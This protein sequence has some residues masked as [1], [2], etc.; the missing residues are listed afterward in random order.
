MYPEERKIPN[1]LI[2]TIEVHIEKPDDNTF[3]DYTQLHNIAKRNCQNFHEKIESLIMDIRNDI[4]KLYEYDSLMIEIEKSPPPTGS[5][6]HS[7]Y[8]KYVDSTK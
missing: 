3:V 2:I 5:S 1:Q 7:S 4:K 8:I 6:L